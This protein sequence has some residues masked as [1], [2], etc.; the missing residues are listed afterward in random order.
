MPYAQTWVNDPAL[1]SS[2]IDTDEPDR[3]A[4]SKLEVI[5]LIAK[6]VLLYR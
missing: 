2:K 6:L 3:R 1:T 4:L 5:G